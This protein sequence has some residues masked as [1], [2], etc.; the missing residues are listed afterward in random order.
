MAMF[1]EGNGQ[2]YEETTVPVQSMLGSWTRQSRAGN[3]GT[4]RRRRHR[5][6]LGSSSLRDIAMRACVQNIDIIP[7]ETLRYYGWHYGNMLRVALENSKLWSFSTWCLFQEAFPDDIDDSDQYY[8]VRVAAREHTAPDLIDS[9]ALHLSKFTFECLT[10]LS[11][12]NLRITKAHMMSL[13]QIPNLAVLSLEQPP[14]HYIDRTDDP[15][16]RFMSIWGRS[17]REKGAFGKLKAIR[18]KHF[19]MGLVDS[20]QVLERFPAL[21]LCNLDAGLVLEELHD[22]DLGSSSFGEEFHNDQWQDLPSEGNLD[23]RWKFKRLRPINYSV[24]EDMERMYSIAT[25]LDQN[26]TS[27][28]SHS[29]LSIDYGEESSKTRYDPS[30]A[31]LWLKRTPQVMDQAHKRSNEEAMGA[32]PKKKKRMEI[33]RNK[34][35]D[36]G[37]MLAGFGG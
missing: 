8:H 9:F 7:A 16:D 21:S 5:N 12:R 25:E 20:L 29:R 33:R 22:I 28:V 34:Q 11:I 14:V 17:V 13:L 32:P 37:S 31:S 1:M 4:R 36:V 23:H 2:V 10:H 15:D 35:K 6:G 18:L 26:A 30:E 27:K 19:A 24:Q 3:L